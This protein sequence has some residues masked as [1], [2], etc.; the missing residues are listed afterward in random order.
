MNKS[1]LFS[2]VVL[3]LV[4]VKINYNIQYVEKRKRNLSYD[5]FY[6]NIDP[7]QLSGELDPE[8]YCCDTKYDENVRYSEMKKLNEWEELPFWKKIVLPD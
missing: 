7:V 5:K 1:F 6:P 2:S 3:S 8:C 4:G